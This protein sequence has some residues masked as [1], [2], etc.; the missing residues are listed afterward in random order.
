[1][2]LERARAGEVLLVISEVTRLELAN[3]RADV[4]AV[5]ASVPTDHLE[6]VQSS[7]EVQ[8]LAERY[9]AEGVI[10]RKM[11]ADALHIAAATVNGGRYAGELEFQAHTQLLSRARV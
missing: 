6:L 9:V 7:D 3:A 1:M 11:M 4:R 10:G 5:L 8:R 2:L